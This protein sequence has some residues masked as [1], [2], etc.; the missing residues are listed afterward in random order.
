MPTHTVLLPEISN[1][2]LEC[3][4]LNNG[5]LSNEFLVKSELDSFI[6]MLKWLRSMKDASEITIE[7]ARIH[8]DIQKSTMRARLMVMPGMDMLSAEK[9]LNQAFDSVRREVF[10]YLE[11]IVI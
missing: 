9:L 4:K 6:L 2:M 7:Q 3:I 5:F 8:V 10:N 11:W 1:K